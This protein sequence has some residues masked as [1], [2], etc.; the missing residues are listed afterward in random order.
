MMRTAMRRLG[1]SLAVS[2]SA[3][4]WAGL[5]GVRSSALAG[6]PANEA[7]LP[8]LRGAVKAQRK[9]IA[10]AKNGP[11]LFEAQKFKSLKELVEFYEEMMLPMH[12]IRDDIY[13]TWVDRCGINS[14]IV[15]TKNASSSDMSS[16]KGHYQELDEKIKS[17]EAER[18]GYVSKMFSTAMFNSILNTLRQ[19]GDAPGCKQMATTIFHDMTENEV[20][21]DET[22]KILLKNIMFGDSIHDNSD[23]LFSHIEYPE[24]GHHTY[25]PSETLEQISERVLGTVGDRHGL[26]TNTDEQLQRDAAFLLRPST[27]IG[28]EE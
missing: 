13:N 8:G 19:A 15:Q 7:E 25:V 1:S 24:R 9:E 4:L 14:K 16:W 18:A 3:M 22:T 10:G 6:L 27:T 5:E 17:L 21:F 11:E 12:K 26:L 23:L 20:A 28:V 2:N